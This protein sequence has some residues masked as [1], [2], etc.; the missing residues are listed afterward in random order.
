MSD[1]TLLAAAGPA[2]PTIGA[3]RPL[4]LRATT[5]HPDGLLGAWQHRNS[6]A[7][8]PHCL[9]QLEAAG[10][11][12][13]L[14]RV[15]TGAG[16]FR[17]MWFAD[18]DVY[19]T[20]EAVAWEI[21]RG[22]GSV[23]VLDD[24]TTLLEQ[25]Q[26]ADGYLNSYF[27]TDHRDEQWAALVWSHELYCAGHLIQAAVAAS[28]AGVGDRLLAVARRFADLLVARF[29]VEDGV[30]GHPEIE[31]ALV[32][33]YRETEHRPY[34]DLAARFVELRGR[35]LLGDE[36]RFGRHYYQDHLPVREADEVTGHAVRQLYLLAG[37]VDVAV[38]TG[39]AGLLDAAARLWESAFGTKT[40]LTGAHGSRHRDEAFGDPYELPPD[41]AYAETC[42]AIASFSWNWRMLLATGG[43]R[44]A[45]ELERVLYNGIAGS[46]ARDG[47]HFFYSNPLQLRTG[48]EGSH[49][50][51][52]S[53]RLSWY[54]C[55]CCPPNL[56]RLVASLQ[57]YVATTTDAGVQVHLYA[58]G[59]VETPFGVV[60][61]ATDY[62]WDGRVTLTVTPSS[63][64]TEWTLDLRIPGW[65]TS[66]TLDG[67]PV[68][69]DYASVTRAWQP[70]EQVV[71]SLPMEPRV[72]SAHPRVDA[73][74]GCV[75]L[76]R[77][78]LVYCLEQADLDVRREDVRLEDVRLD[79]GAPI[80]AEPRDG[81]IP[82]VLTAHGAVASSEGAPLYGG[83]PSGERAP[84]TLTAIP[85]FLWANREPGAMRVW[86]P[87]AT[88]PRS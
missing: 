27:Q 67:S 38:E 44:Y 17:G 41:R 54:S 26:D 23:E 68:A 13:N 36:P 66:A 8:L 24:F 47:T 72:T 88:G 25:A 21:G 16:E 42:A 43:H 87:T 71:L 3:L 48:H 64:G 31:T 62:P 77:G 76:L 39:D 29:S 59:R 55:A 19:K 28:R 57:S 56:A 2:A 35:G 80:E 63:P 45:D 85:Y 11:V 20:L 86:I 22:T 6:T 33:L 83:G 79:D 84:V 52:P 7:S 46:T 15:T 78:P 61:V 12:G 30:C 50:D 18:S 34:L 51:A 10:N 73:V 9:D 4:G 74:R 75:A 65:C 40:Y 5:L 60:D 70:G 1:T 32:E 82:V 69:G 81:A 37:V 49:E 53:E 58:A 14:R